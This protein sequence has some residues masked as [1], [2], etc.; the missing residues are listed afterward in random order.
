MGARLRK[1]VL[2]TS[3]P[4]SSTVTRS[5]FALSQPPNGPVHSRVTMVRGAEE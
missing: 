5:H 2:L 3:E 1:T 4:R